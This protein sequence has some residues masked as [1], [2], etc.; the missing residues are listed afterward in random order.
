MPSLY[1]MVCWTNKL[2]PHACIQQESCT[3]PVARSVHAMLLLKTSLT[4]VNYCLCISQRWT[5]RSALVYFFFT[6]SPLCKCFLKMILLLSKELPLF[7]VVWTPTYNISVHARK[8]PSQTY[9]LNTKKLPFKLNAIYNILKF[10]LTLDMM[11]LEKNAKDS[12]WMWFN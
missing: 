1:F 3:L 4:I 12:P 9:G 2:M 7:A 5:S 11:S 10:R 6:I 8:L